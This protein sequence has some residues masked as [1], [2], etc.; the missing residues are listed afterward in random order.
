MNSLKTRIG[1]LEQAPAMRGANDLAEAQ[2]M[3]VAQNLAAIKARCQRLLEVSENPS[4]R[5]G[6][7][8]TIAEI[9]GGQFKIPA[10]LPR[11]YD[12]RAKVMRER[13]MAD[14]GD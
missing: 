5:E 1:Q 3:T 4:Q 7:I 11:D 12:A 13:M 9:E 10:P 14:F 6:L 2:R 8:R